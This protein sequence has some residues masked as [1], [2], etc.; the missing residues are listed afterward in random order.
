MK[1]SLF[2]SLGMRRKAPVLA[3]AV[4][5]AVSGCTGASDG[6]ERVPVHE[7]VYPFA[8]G[9]S[10]STGRFE[11]DSKLLYLLSDGTE[12]LAARSVGPGDTAKIVGG[13]CAGA[14][15]D[16]EPDAEKAIVEFYEQQGALYDLEEYLEKAYA[17]YTAQ[18][19]RSQFRCYFLD[20]ET[21][22]SA[23][24]EETVSC[25]TSLRFP[26]DQELYDDCR[27][28]RCFDRETGS[29]IDEGYDGGAP[30]EGTFSPAP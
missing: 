13:E 4:L 26:I 24:D 23:L 20:Q 7:N 29:P 17:E 15:D 22:V 25:T 19:D 6:V 27:V 2:C 1:G 3:L 8:D 30:C 28:T 10:V 14:L 11:N 16:L 5:L 9:E 18:E 12:L 21:Y